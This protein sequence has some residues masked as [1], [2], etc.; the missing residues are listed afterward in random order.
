MKLRKQKYKNATDVKRA[1]CDIKSLIPD[2]PKTP[3]PLLE[4]NHLLSAN[5][6]ARLEPVE[7]NPTG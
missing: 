1:M 3:V 5:K 4:Q 2:C 7:I 6:V